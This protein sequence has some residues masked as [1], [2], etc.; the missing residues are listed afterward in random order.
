LPR[1]SIARPSIGRPSLVADV[2][3]RAADVGGRAARSL[4]AMAR[5]GVREVP[6]LGPIRL[7][8]A[9]ASAGAACLIL[10][11]LPALGMPAGGIRVIGGAL[12]AL[13]YLVG[14]GPRDTRR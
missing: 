5:P 2:G 13:V 12:A 9:I 1:P 4:R 3:G 11:G 10:V 8:P 14:T 6:L 7:V